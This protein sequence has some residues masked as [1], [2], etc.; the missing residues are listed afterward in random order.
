MRVELNTGS[1]SRDTVTVSETA[2]SFSEKS[3]SWVTPRLSVTSV[4]SSVLNPASDA[5]HLVGSAD[6]HAGNDE[7]TVSLGVASYVVPEGS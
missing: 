2:A 1:A 4:R 7:A 6:A 5:R 3:R